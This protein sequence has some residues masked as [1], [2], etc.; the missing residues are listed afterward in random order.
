M[1][2][3]ALVCR[4][5]RS[6]VGD[7]DSGA[8]HA[9]GNWLPRNASIYK[10]MPSVKKLTPTLRSLDLVS[11]HQSKD[12]LYVGQ[13]TRNGEQGCCVQLCRLGTAQRCSLGLC[14][15]PMALGPPETTGLLRGMGPGIVAHLGNP[16][17]GLPGILV[18]G[19]PAQAQLKSPLAVAWQMG[20]R[21]GVHTC[22]QSSLPP[23]PPP[24]PA[25]SE[26]A[27]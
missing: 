10:T 24:C 25:L 4:P 7:Y 26:K 1:P 6:L 17:S 14:G 9:C 16:L 15:V 2:F 19:Q 13:G 18:L 3:M 22:R 8:Q 27:P 5:K 11:R 20:A 21:P 12:F 23:A